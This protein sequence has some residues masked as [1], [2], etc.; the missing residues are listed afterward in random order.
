MQRHCAAERLHKSGVRTRDE[1]PAAWTVGSQRERGDFEDRVC[2]LGNERLT[3]RTKGQHAAAELHA[4]PC[5]RFALLHEHSPW[6][7]W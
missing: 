7:G 3:G 2:R 6:H 1:S 5:E 4:W